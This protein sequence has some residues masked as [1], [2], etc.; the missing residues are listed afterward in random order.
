M[1]EPD[2]DQVE[3]NL[4]VA[5][6]LGQR[7]L[8]R[9]QALL[10][11]Q[12][13]TRRALAEKD[14]MIQ[15]LQARLL[16]AQQRSGGVVGERDALDR[17][18]QA[19]LDAE[20][21]RDINLERILELQRTVETMK[22]AAAFSREKEMIQSLN[23]R[24][25]HLVTLLQKKDEE[26][27]RLGNQRAK[28]ESRVDSL[29]LKLE[30]LEEQA[31]KD[32]MPL[33][34]KS[35]APEEDRDGGRQQENEDRDDR[36]RRE[37]MLARSL[38]EEAEQALRIERAAVETKDVI[39]NALQQSL[40]ELK[41][42]VEEQEI[43]IA[44]IV[45]KDV[46][47]AQLVKGNMSHIEAPVVVP[48]RTVYAGDVSEAN[49]MDE[50]ITYKSRYACREGAD[51]EFVMR[52]KKLMSV[53]DSARLAHVEKDLLARGGKPTLEELRR[54][55][56]ARVATAEDEVNLLRLSP[57]L[58]VLPYTGIVF[59]H[60]MRHMAILKALH[61]SM[62]ELKKAPPKDFSFSFFKNGLG[63]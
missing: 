33:R 41:R 51:Q 46:S 34:R 29:L 40:G 59:E 63:K 16:Q 17:L 47:F 19:K 31:K 36:L 8:R 54:V 11:E 24:L 12:V 52:W 30:T 26:I 3:A 44:R 1:L 27:D 35:F 42:K 61:A 50:L 45:G 39:I 18:A 21:Q 23:Q 53:L 60:M 58:Q 25:E 20:R 28:L 4:H 43:E 9:N 37:L 15:E 32:G 2:A 14:H 22:K 6:E 10:E 62:F 57:T 13:T 49:L 7:L 55:A 56:D 38:K 48:A 5:V